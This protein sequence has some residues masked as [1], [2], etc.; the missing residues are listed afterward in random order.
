VNQA[1]RRFAR[2]LGRLGVFELN[3]R[4]NYPC[5]AD[6]GRVKS[7][8]SFCLSN[9]LQTGMRGAYGKPQGLCARVKIGQIIFSCRT[10][11]G[12]EEHIIEAF[13]KCK[14][15]FPGQQLVIESKKWGFTKLYKKDYLKLREEG[16]LIADGITCK[17]RVNSLPRSLSRV[18]GCS[19]VA[20][21]IDSQSW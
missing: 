21:H 3:K 17:V 2:N 14:F 4:E 10:T 7:G 6:A 15:K 9:R 18:A 19:I 5:V 12:N 1:K 8:L 11:P 13:R 20:A 16:K